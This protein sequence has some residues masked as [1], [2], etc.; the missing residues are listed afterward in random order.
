MMEKRTISVIIPTYKPDKRF[1]QLIEGLERQ[2]QRPMQILVINTEEPAWVLS[3]ALK[4][5]FEAGRSGSGIPLAVCHIGREEF[6]HGGT[7]AAA[8]AMTDAEILLFMTQDA[9]PADEYLIERLVRRLGNGDG[10]TVAAAYARQLPAEDCHFLERYTRTF[11]YPAQ[12]A[13]RSQKDLPRL[14]IKT[15]LCSNVCAAYVRRAYEK[16]GGFE[17]QIIFNEDMVLAARLI[18]AGY[19]IAYE[20]D[21]QVIHSHN[22]SGAQ[23]FHRNFDLA[24]SQADYPEIFAQVRSES[25]GIRLVK[26]TA[27][28][29][30]KN[31]RFYLLPKLIWQSGCKYLGYF[32]GKHYRR[33]PAAWVRW[34]SMNRNFWKNKL[35]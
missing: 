35:F 9:V 30:M 34:C 5:K 15:Y 32:A 8:A 16:M 2:T 12:S 17:K 28:Y 10:E 19:R 4:A 14:G 24:V 26:D 11:N 7:R 31:G 1:E 13:V 3:S 20:A 22:Y 33:L 18:K 6:D 29:L 27:R 21:A 23:Q 25:E